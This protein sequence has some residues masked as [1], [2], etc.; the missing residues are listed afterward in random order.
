[1]DRQRPQGPPAFAS[2]LAIAFLGERLHLFH[3]ASM[4]MILGGIW[5]TSRADNPEAEA[6]MG[7]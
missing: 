6:G 4:A 7:N 5:L 1:L 3:V 2:L